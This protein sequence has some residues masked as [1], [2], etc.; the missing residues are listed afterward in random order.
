MAQLCGEVAWR[1]GGAWV[2]QSI[3]LLGMFSAERARDILY[4]STQ[5]AQRERAKEDNDE[6][7]QV[8]REIP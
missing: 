7:R 2:A 3:F 5:P 8:Y 4:Q 1:M 6:L